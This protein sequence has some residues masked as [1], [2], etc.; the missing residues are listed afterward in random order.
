M[1]LVTNPER[2]VIKETQRAHLYI[3]LLGF[4]IVALFGISGAL[5]VGVV[6]A[7]SCPGGAT[8]NL[9][10]FLG[11]GNVALSITLT[12][13]ATI[14][15]VF[16]MP[17]FTELAISRQ[18]LDEVGVSLPLLETILRLVVIVIIPVGIGMFIRAR[19]ARLAAKAETVV[20]VFGLV[21]LVALIVGITASLWE[22]VPTYLADA[23][24]AMLL[25]SL[26]GLAIGLV[27]AARL[28]VPDRVAIAVEMGVKNSTIGILVA[29]LVSPD[30]VY[31]VPSAVYGVLM[32]VT[33]AGVVLY[34]RRA[35]RRH[36]ARV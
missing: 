17:V 5:A 18:G 10:A 12:V 1:R 29:T 16:T 30:F 21:V 35:T 27:A 11:K 13:V 25:L 3:S 15:A 2:M 19:N 34:G 8:S 22:D 28:D 20:S 31:A 36:N 14:L 4:G 9:V 7:A 6:I 26:L 33:V 24:P 23:G 32:Y